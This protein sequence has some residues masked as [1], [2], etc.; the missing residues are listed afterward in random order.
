VIW[1]LAFV[2]RRS[3]PATTVH[4]LS[5]CIFSSLNTAPESAMPALPASTFVRTAFPSRTSTPPEISVK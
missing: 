3:A 4:E 2:V 1:P 5:G